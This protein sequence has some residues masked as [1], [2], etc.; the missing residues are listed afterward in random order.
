VS[1][2]LTIALALIGLCGCQQEADDLCIAGDLGTYR[3]ES[4]RK[5]PAGC[6]ARYVDPQGRRARVRVIPGGSIQRPDGGVAFPFEKHTVYSQRQPDGVR[7]VWHKGDL[8]VD[9]FLQGLA[10]PQG[11]V[12]R[13]YLFEY[14][15]DVTEEVEIA[16][17]EVDQLKESSRGRPKDA[18]VHLELARKYRKLND[19]VMATQEYHI[20]VD[21]D[22]SCYDCYL[23]MGTLY[24]EL[25]HWD[26]AIRALRRAAALRPKEARP[27]LLLGD[28]YYH[29]RNG[30]EAQRAY[31][32][33]LELGLGGDEKKKVDGR[34]SELK[35]GKYMI[36]VMPGARNRPKIP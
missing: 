5:L 11:A 4:V 13:A 20:A 24:F 36:E 2:S 16:R 8:A 28:V 10:V 22:R 27:A 34:L 32:R 14:R 7:V 15:S 23:E 33:A 29:V 21:A 6:E 30:Q 9:M 18:A 3:F 35:D 1:K 25:K 12:L 26:L 19:T 17:A 31:L